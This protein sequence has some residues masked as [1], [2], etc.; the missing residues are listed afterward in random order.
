MS[1]TH[2]PRPGS[3]PRGRGGRRWRGRGLLARRPG[4]FDRGRHW[5]GRRLDS[6]TATAGRSACGCSGGDCD[7]CVGRR[8]RGCR[9]LFCAPGRCLRADRG[10]RG[11]VDPG[12]VAGGRSGDAGGEG[13]EGP[14]GVRRGRLRLRRLRVPAK[15]TPPARH[16]VQS[17]P[18]DRPEPAPPV[19]EPGA[20]RAEPAD[21]SATSSAGGTSGTSPTGLNSRYPSQ[22]LNA[23][24]LRRTEN[25]P[26]HVRAALAQGRRARP[27]SCPRRASERASRHPGEATSRVSP[28]RRGTSPTVIGAGSANRSSGSVGPGARTAI[29]GASRFDASE[30]PAAALPVRKPEPRQGGCV[31]GVGPATQSGWPGQRRQ[32]AD[33]VLGGM[34][35]GSIGARALCTSIPCSRSSASSS[36]RT[37]CPGHERL[38]LVDRS[39]RRGRRRRRGLRARAC[40]A[41]FAMRRSRM[42][43]SKLLQA[44]VFDGRTRGAASRTRPP[45]LMPG[46]P[47]LARVTSA[48]SACASRFPGQRSSSSRSMASASSIRP[49]AM[50]RRARPRAAT[51]SRRAV[52][53]ELMDMRLRLG[54]CTMCARA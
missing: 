3:P 52:R 10:P 29:G 15:A 49:A 9:A 4:R 28:A 5:D 24:T 53:G 39:K 37:G 11:I 32:V 42:R 47:P 20:G 13:V 41:H 54:R 2:H 6:G 46:V 21:A 44:S 34:L 40:S 26:E 48:S 43:C 25:D 8:R 19:R 18:S 36:S 38:D 51:R 33:A 23:I 7:W 1:P 12:R 45:G 30:R 22:P 14:G 31:L 50:A 16:L 17:S 35:G 27:S